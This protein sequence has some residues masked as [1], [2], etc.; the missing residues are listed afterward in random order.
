MTD[1]ALVERFISPS[2]NPVEE[3][4]AIE[5]KKRVPIQ[6]DGAELQSCHVP[7]NF[8]LND[9]SVE[10]RSQRQSPD[11]RRDPFHLLFAQLV[12]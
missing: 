2:L 12:E 6:S 11:I 7:G 1:K 3:Y 10:G 8:L 4:A 5:S 9:C